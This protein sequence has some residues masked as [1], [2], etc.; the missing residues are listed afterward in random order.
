M[1]IDLLSVILALLFVIG[2]LA[3][4]SV[5]AQPPDLFAASPPGAAGGK[6]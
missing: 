5:T 4:D 2:L 1:K 3:I 6:F